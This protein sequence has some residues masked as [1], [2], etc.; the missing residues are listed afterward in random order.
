MSDIDKRTKVVDLPVPCC[1][2]C[3]KPISLQPLVEQAIE[4]ARLSGKGA[5]VLRLMMK[6]MSGKEIAVLLGNSE[7]TIKSQVATIFDRFGVNGRFE[8]MHLIFPS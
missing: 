7:K 2:H 4:T 6:G 3:Q 1:E 5:D 8:L